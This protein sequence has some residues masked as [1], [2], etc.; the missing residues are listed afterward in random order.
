MSNDSASVKERRFII[1]TG[2]FLAV[3]LALA[4]LVIFLIGKEN[5]LF[6][7]QNSYYASFEN[8]DGLKLD[9]PVRLGGL[10]VGVVSSIS[11]YPDPK[12]RRIRVQ[13]EISDVFADRI[14][15]DSVA[16]LSNRGVLGDKAI[17]ITLGTV[18]KPEV[19]DN[20]EIE[21]GSSGDIGALLKSSGEIVE[22]AV[23][24]SR[25]LRK[26]VSEY[27]DSKVRDDILGTLKSIGSLAKDARAGGGVVQML[28]TD[29]QAAE[30]AKIAVHQASRASARLDGSLREMESILN[31]VHNGEGAVHAIIY[32]KK[33]GRAFS[34][35]GEAASELSSILH[36][37][38]KTPQS[39]VH[40]LVYGD[41]RNLIK[42]LGDAANDIKKI[43]NKV[44]QGQGSLGLLINDPTVYEDLKTILGNV[45]RN[46]VLR[47]LV[48][49]S[50]SNSDEIQEAGE[51]KEKGGK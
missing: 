32:D 47:A 10:D 19:P 12:D 27:T 20:G 35:L 26:A 9:S 15:T 51:V 49:Y 2:I 24:I 6:D 17:D 18:D 3:G 1:R 7:K 31:E 46:R 16:K 42:D 44:A 36:D 28:L 21:G 37:A 11:F 39:A 50:I 13:M 41:S 8:V 34:E 4:G 33:T 43:T 48:R 22:N 29:K 23:V 5:R 30:D 40:Q 14:R 38:K 45:K 25:D